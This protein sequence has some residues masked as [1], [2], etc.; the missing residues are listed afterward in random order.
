[1][2]VVVFLLGWFYNSGYKELYRNMDEAS[3]ADYITQ[4][5]PGVETTTNFGYTL[6]F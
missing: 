1:L 4:T 5:F 3:A 2:R 6:F